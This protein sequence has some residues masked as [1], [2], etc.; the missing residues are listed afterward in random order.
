[1]TD[2]STKKP[3]TALR[4]PPQLLQGREVKPGRAAGRA[5]AL[6]RRRTAAFIERVHYTDSCDMQPTDYFLDNFVA[7]KLSRLT[8]CGAC[9]LTTN[10]NWI[11]GF[12]L[13][14][15]LTAP[16]P[17]K[18][19][20][21]AFNFVRRAE[22]AFSAYRQARTALIEYFQTPRNV[23]SPYFRALLNFEVCIAQCCQG[24]ELRATASGERSPPWKKKNDK[25][26]LGC[27]YRLY[28]DSKHMDGMID[29]GQLPTEATAAIWITNIGL[30]SN[31]AAVTFDE[32]FELLRH[33][34]EIA[35]QLSRLT[36]RTAAKPGS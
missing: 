12:V 9:E 23:I 34:G 5:D 6:R 1:M 28:I 27:L 14:R 30:E 32:L 2:W 3:T 22:G 25:S 21:H 26:E 4:R 19:R 16:L 7:H 15:A 36:Q 24:Y 31:R 13:T 17:P 11:S 10:A 20:E 8:K 29:G 33:M 35:D 18:Q